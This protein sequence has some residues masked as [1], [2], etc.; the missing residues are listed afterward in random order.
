MLVDR[1]Y[2]ISV[3]G[4]FDSIQPD[5]DTML[6]FMEHFGSKGFVP[7]LYIEVVA[8]PNATM[9]KQRV[10]LVANNE[11]KKISIGSNRID[12]EFGQT[13]DVAFSKETRNEFNGFASDA[14]EFI[15]SR[16]R[17]TS[18]RLAI[19]TESLLIDLTEEQVDRFNR[20]FTTPISIYSNTPL[21]EW[22]IRL[23]AKKQEKVNEKTEQFNVITVI[24]KTVLQKTENNQPVIT[25]GFSISG[26]LNTVGENQSYRFNNND[27]S[28]FLVIVNSW[29][30]SIL[31]DAGDEM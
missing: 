14:I 9:Q 7:S 17:K 30:D 24:K 11:N 2:K 1:I 27:L 12:I 28:C 3:F 22:S 23:V 21:K 25:E 31:K 18:N 19:N 6:V 15:F 8:S 13:E 29:L 16:F 10:A 4:E 26:D 5:P 20:R